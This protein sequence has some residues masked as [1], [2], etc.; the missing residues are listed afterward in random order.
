[1]ARSPSHGV[2]TLQWFF[3]PDRTPKSAREELLLNL[4][5]QWMTLTLLES[6]AFASSAQ[7][8]APLGVY[9]VQF[10]RIHQKLPQPARANVEPLRSQLSKVHQ[11][12]DASED[13]DALTAKLRQLPAAKRRALKAYQVALEAALSEVVQSP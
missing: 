7:E 4:Q 8:W 13:A 9:L 10:G 1:M 12:W 5:A 11:A 6:A 3:F 2:P